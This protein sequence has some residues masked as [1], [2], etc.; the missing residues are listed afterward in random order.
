MNCCIKLLSRA[1][2][3]FVILLA[4][5]SRLEKDFNCRS[6]SI[7]DFLNLGLI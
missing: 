5:L 7:E 2:I 4:N 3:F 1:V 6:G